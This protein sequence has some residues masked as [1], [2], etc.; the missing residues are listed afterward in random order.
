M[1][2]WI[3]VVAG[4]AGSLWIAPALA[5][6]CTV[7]EGAELSIETGET[8]FSK[9]AKPGDHFP[10]RL[11]QPLTI[12]GVTAIPAGATG[13]GEVIHAARSSGWGKSGEL[14]LAARYLDIG[15]TRLPLRAFR[16]NSA[17]AQQHG[18]IFTGTTVARTITAD[19]IQV[20][21]GT[22]ATAK[23]A[24]AIEVPC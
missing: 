19:D 16:I 23:A 15:G 8:I 12:D 2:R 22:V 13:M 9:T 4:L 17:G 1:R 5:A 14:I 10:I 18:I 24:Q 20:D 6:T 11:G 7:P 3:A 21:A